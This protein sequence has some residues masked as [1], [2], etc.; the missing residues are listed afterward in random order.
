MFGIIRPCRNRMGAELRSAWLA[1]LCGMCLSLRDEHGHLSR[2][3]T[4]YDGL[5]ISAMVEALGARPT[6]ERVRLRLREA[7]VDVLVATPGRLLDLMNQGH[8]DLRGVEVLVL[9]EAHYVRNA[10]TQRAKRLAREREPADPVEFGRE[11]GIRRSG[12]RCRI[13]GADD[14]SRLVELQDREPVRFRQFPQHPE[15][16]LRASPARERS[17]ERMIK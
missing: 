2:L 4:N 5:M 16:S 15:S 11:H 6:V 17:I 7:G 13:D 1:H 3:V 8:V 12:G 14:P 9:D 10:E